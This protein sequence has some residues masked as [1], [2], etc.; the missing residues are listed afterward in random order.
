MKEGKIIVF[1]GPSGSG[2]NTIINYLMEQGLNMRFSISATSRPPRG[3]EQNGVAYWFLSPEEF[4][5]R[6]DN[7]DFIEYCE[8]FEGRYYGTLKSEVDRQLAEGRNIVADLDVVGAE[9]IK[10]IYGKQALSVFIQPP[11]LEVLRQRL[12]DRGTETPDVIEKRLARAE[13]ELGEAKKFDIIIVND[14]LST[15]Q[16]EALQRVGAYLKDND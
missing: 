2:K 6:I 4:R 8:V 16:A 10:R 14:E 5:R 12:T 7:G 13:Y 1:A 15:A 3:E 9:N 11:S